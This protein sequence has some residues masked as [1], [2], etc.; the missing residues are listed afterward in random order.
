MDQLAE[1][2][3]KGGAGWVILAA[4]AICLPVAI[5][6]HC[7]I[8]GALASANSRLQAV[9]NAAKER[10]QAREE[11]KIR[12]RQQATVAQLGMRGLENRPLGDFLDEAVGM[13]AAMLDVE[14]CGF[15]EFTSQ[16]DKLALT[17]GVGW[18]P[19]V[20]RARSMEVDAQATR[21]LAHGEPVI[22]EDL[23]RESRFVPPALLR[24]HGVASGATV[25][26]HSHDKPFGVL[27]AWT[28]RL[29]LLGEDDVNFLQAVANVL[30]A[31]LER[32]E[33]KRELQEYAAELKAANQELERYAAVTDAS[34]RAKSDFL[35]NMSHEIRTPMTAIL[36]YSELLMAGN[37][38]LAEQQ[39]NLLAIQRNGE[40]LLNLI[41]DILDLSKIEA[42]K[43]TVERIACSPGAVVADVASMM[44]ARAAA[45]G[46]DFEIRYESPVPETIH[47]DPTRLRQVL[48]N[49][50]SNALKFTER[51]GL[52]I[53]CRMA[54]PVDAAEPMLAFD[55]IDTG[56]GMSPEAV[57]RL[58]RPF[59]QADSSTTRKYGGT[60][61]GL[62]ISKR[63]AQALGGDIDLR[64]SPGEGSTF[65]VTIA[66]GPLAGTRL[67]DC[68]SEDSCDL[69]AIDEL[70]APL[71]ARRVLLAE[72]GADNQYLI[73]L[74]LRSAGA[75]VVVSENGRL[76][77]EMALEARAAGAPFHVILMDMQMPELDGYQATALLRASGYGGPIVALTANAMS[78]DRE[79]CLGQGCDDYLTKPIKK[80]DLLRVAAA[81]ADRAAG[82]P[83]SDQAAVEPTDA[84]SDGA[85]L[86]SSLIDDPLMADAVRR[87]VDQLD[88]TLD[89][90]RRAF[91]SGDVPR[92]ASLAHQL[93]G[94]AGGYGFD[95]ITS[96]A[97]LLESAA[98]N[99]TDLC[100]ATAALDALLE[101]G[102]RAKA[103]PLVPCS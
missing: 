42:G 23:L 3:I 78:G 84:E 10:D 94:A 28:T 92:C 45:K 81:H 25:A 1:F 85:P 47:S 79:R 43:L 97:A 13:V 39:R 37:A 83:S 103:A 57:K 38:D 35:A 14:F 102:R 27:G 68:P 50:V 12:E 87:F 7:R 76:A 26:I 9:L 46:L 93:K 36:G 4:V 71:A 21:V 20:V 62:T 91:Q 90:L 63:L 33:T 6:L 64:S 95:Q 5:W 53:A 15:L 99:A 54:T 96:A 101:L 41:N 24:N 59:T 67:V 22:V 11:A 48:V 30:S 52:R 80:A 34:T 19:S 49:L 98:K 65:A 16:R 2:W 77:V 75:E 66:T 89:Q 51:G 55:V 82:P 88:V 8:T 40:H 44:R 60:G 86:V 32:E 17:S 69:V 29:R 56:I 18:D 73:S 61:L 100:A 58:F 31:V 72:D 74:L 70:A